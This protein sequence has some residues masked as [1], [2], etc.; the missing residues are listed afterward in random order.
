VFCDR[1]T[2]QWY[3]GVSTLHGAG[4]HIGG[5]AFLIVIAVDVGPTIDD[6][7]RATRL[8]LPRVSRTFSLGIKLLPPKLELPIRVGYLLCRLA[9]TIEDDFGMPSVRK[10]ELLDLFLTCFDDTRA[11]NQI[12]SCVSELRANDAAAELI[13]LAGSVFLMW[14]TL[15]MKSREIIRHWVT[16]MA[17]GMRIFVLKYPNG[18]R[19]ATV[20][21]FR[22][23][24]YFV[25]GTV[26]H[27]LTDLWHAHSVFVGSRSQARLLSDC[28]AFGEALQIVNIIKDIGR[29]SERENAIY[30]PGELLAAYGSGHD[31]LLA[32]DYR[33]TNRKAL[34]PLMAIARED[35]ERSLRY[36]EALPSGA[37]RVRLFC[38]L[39]MLFAVATIREL[40]Q[41]DG[42]LDPATAVKITRAE[43]EA[44]TF[45]GCASTLT[46]PSLRWLVDRVRERPFALGFR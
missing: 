9:D 30:I 40:E 13:E 20:A 45:A 1:C 10:A 14:R 24:C 4:W 15:D 17:R 44:L 16:E 43:V 36:I 12:G 23:Y 42:M 35:I 27:L 8:I 37:I 29:D 39:P 7:Q 33:A 25:A 32:D 2:W 5:K 19:I 28:E 46:N 22:E 41:T 21:E 6:A 18:I 3:E 26:G 11:A 31:T 34:E 38:A